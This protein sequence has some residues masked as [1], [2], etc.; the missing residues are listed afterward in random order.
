VNDF[1]LQLKAP[2]GA[3]ELLSL[4]SQ[5]SQWL[6]GL[7]A[8][9]DDIYAAMSVL[10]EIA[11]NLMEHSGAQWIELKA[12]VVAGRIQ[13]ALRDN[14]THFDSAEAARKDYSGYLA[15][16]T[17]RRLGLFLIGRLTDDLRYEREEPEGVNC[18]SFFL[19]FKSWKAPERA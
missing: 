18:L 15:T 17:D 4:R 10:D 9:G 7:G 8:P 14:G 12:L 6:A 3:T 1:A 11:S 13:L 5:L 19:K 16:D 2:L